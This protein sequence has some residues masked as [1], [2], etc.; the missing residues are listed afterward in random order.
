M[1]KHGIW[2]E[3]WKVTA[4][5]VDPQQRIRL[6]SIADIFQE[7]ANNHANFRKCGFEDMKAGGKFWVLNRQVIEISEWPKWEQQIKVESWISMM[8]GPFSLRHFAAYNEN[9]ELIIKASY[10]WTSIDRAKM[11]PI[12]ISS[13]DLPIIETRD[14]LLPQPRKIKVSGTEIVKN[15]YRVRESD[16]D[17]IGHTNNATYLEWASNMFSDL[18]PGFSKIEANYTGESFAGQQVTISLLKDEEHRYAVD[19]INHKDQSI[20]RLKVE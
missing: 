3:K 6:K 8:K 13:T 10:L 16:L 14:F 2:E 11:K 15:I 18:L 19:V 17:I 4:F 20:F 7:L 1:E 12:S 9:N 5:M